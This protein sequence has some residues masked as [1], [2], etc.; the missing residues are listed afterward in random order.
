MLGLLA[1]K[2][3]FK[4]E[5]ALMGPEP[6][7]ERFQPYRSGREA[8]AFGRQS[9]GPYLAPSPVAITRSVFKATRTSSHSEMFLM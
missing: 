1:G 4:P 9:G 6:D 2:L 3:F 5:S 8:I 7:R